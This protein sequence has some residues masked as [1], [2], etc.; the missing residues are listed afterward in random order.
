MLDQLDLCDDLAQIGFASKRGFTFANGKHVQGRG[1]ALN[2]WDNP[3]TFFDHSLH[4]RLKYCHPL[5]TYF[6]PNRQAD[7]SLQ[8]FVVDSSTRSKGVLSAR[9]NRTLF[10]QIPRMSSVLDSKS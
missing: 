6:W 10:I 4:I 7:T 8:M 3:A 2:L 9:A 5:N 1:L